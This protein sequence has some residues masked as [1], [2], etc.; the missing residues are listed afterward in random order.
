[1]SLIRNLSEKLKNIN[2][3]QKERGAIF[4]LTALLLPIMF[5]CLG[6]AYDVGTIYM[7]KSRLQNVADAAALAGGRAYI[8]SQAKTTGTKDDIDEDEN[9]TGHGVKNPYTYT[10]AGINN[11]TG[12]DGITYGNSRK[13]AD[14]D[15]AADDYIYKNIINL[16]ETVKADRYSHFALKGIKK[17]ADAEGEETT[18][19]STDDVFYRVGLEE[20]VPL[21]FLPVITNKNAETVRAGSVVLVQ[22]GTTTVIPGS[23]G[24]S[25]TV[26]NP[27]IFDNLFTYSEYFDTGLANENNKVNATYVGNMVFTYGNGSSSQS[28]FY[29]IDKIINNSTQSVEHIFSDDTDAADYLSSMRDNPSETSASAWAK[30]NDPTIDT[31]YNTTAYASAFENKLNETHIDVY[32]TSLSASDINDHNGSLYN[33]QVKIDNKSVQQKG[34]VLYIK[35]GSDSVYYA[36]D[37]STNAYMY[38][39][40]EGV[41]YQVYY[42]R[43][44]N[45]NYVC[46]CVNVDGKYYLLNENGTRS[47]CYVST[48]EFNNQ[49]MVIDI[50]GDGKHPLRYENDTWQYGIADNGGN[51]NTWNNVQQEQLRNSSYP[52][53]LINTTFDQNDTQYTAHI[54]SNV[55]HF[56]RAFQAYVNNVDI[57]ITEALDLDTENPATPIYIIIDNTIDGSINFTCYD[58][59]RPVILVYLGT[60]NIKLQNGGDENTVAKLTIYAPY[61]SVGITPDQEQINYIGTFYGNIIARRVANQASGGPGGKWIQQ[62]FL[63]SDDYTDT[64]VAQATQDIVSNISSA[65]LPD[66]IKADV[67]NTYATSLGIEVSDLTDSLFYSKLGYNDK[68]TLYNAWKTLQDR[69]SDYA[70]YL[71]PWN[72]HFNIESGED[73]TVTTDETIRLI[74]YRTE[75]QVNEDGSIPENKVLDPFIFV[76]LEQPVSY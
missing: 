39:E 11:R 45:A 61:G 65:T 19:T 40:E 64:D 42:V 44:Q 7:H 28:V 33:Q 27:S 24:G 13:H 74:N 23:G 21:H 50:S 69:Y 9:H 22:P 60:G 76:S 49:K 53:P 6:I 15:K 32:K 14:A 20:T 54:E 62:N 25:T 16:G 48:T 12:I 29:N 59:V 2:C 43:P 55:F 17:N 1:M 3:I 72:E 38:I 18:Y 71:W 66:N 10:I 36:V 4:V 41:N 68:Q 52:A 63:E 8:E 35:D 75:Y 51:F 47:N 73:Q 70:D 58:N 37:P 57:S 34:G 46:K 31:Y 30:V 5:G 67:L 56:S 26:T